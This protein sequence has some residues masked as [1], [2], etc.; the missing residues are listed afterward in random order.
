M[1]DLAPDRTEHRIA[2]VVHTRQEV[3]LNWSDGRASRLHALRLRDNCPCPQ[4]RHPQALE[5]THMFINHAIPQ[6]DTAQ[7][8]AAGNLLV[9]FRSAEGAHNS[10]FSA[11]WLR[12]NCS[13]AAARTERKR[14]PHL[15][16]STEI[17][18]LPIVDF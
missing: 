6:I 8:D 3:V 14:N 16:T 17:R 5:R 9:R 11:G 2:A 15:W 10:G 18:D 7:L 1:L 13:S 12:R 4:C